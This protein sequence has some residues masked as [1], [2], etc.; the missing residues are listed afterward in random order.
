MSVI[1]DPVHWTPH[2]RLYDKLLLL[3]MGGYFSIFAF[4][5]LLLHPEATLETLL[6][7]ST[8]TLAFLMLHLI[9]CIGP[10]CRLDPAGGS[11]TPRRGQ[12]HE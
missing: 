1:Y 3:F 10:L 12:D 6:I 5:Q 9:L 7:R 11:R 8:G 4:V 2:K